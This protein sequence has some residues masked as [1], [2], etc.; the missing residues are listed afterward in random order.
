MVSPISIDNIFPFEGKNLLEFYTREGFSVNIE[1]DIWVLPVTNRAS[2]INFSNIQNLNLKGLIKDFI[3]DQ[4]SRVS[5]TSALN[6]F[7]EISR[8]I[9]SRERDFKLFNDISSKEFEERLISLI[10]DV[11]NAVRRK[12][13]LH[14]FYR[15]REWYVW[16]SEVYPEV[17]FSELYANQLD[18]M[19]IPGNP[20]GE[21]VRMQDPESGPLDR[22]LE[23]PLLINAL[24]EDKSNLYIHLQQ[25][26]VIALSLAFGRNPSNLTYLLESDLEDKTLGIGGEP[27]Y[28]LKMPRIKKGLLNPRDDFIEEYLNSTFAAHVKALINAPKPIQIKYG[29]EEDSKVT[30]NPLF[31]NLS[32]NSYAIASGRIDCKYNMLSTGIGKLIKDFIKRH[33]LVSPLTQ[34]LLHITPRR[35]RY[36]FATGLVLEG[37]SSR[38]LARA[39][40]HTDTQNTTVYFELGEKIVAPLDR[41]IEKGFSKNLNYFKGKIVESEDEAINGKR[42]DKSVFFFDERNIENQEMIGICGEKQLCRLDPPYSCYLCPKFQP[43]RQADHEHVLNC[44]IAGRE[45]K[46]KKYENARLGI[47]LDEVIAAVS[48]VARECERLGKND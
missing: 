43:Y 47:Q 48:Q 12:H 29:D 32:G 42:N 1:S 30:I 11:I 40:D 18:A 16:C 8:F 7:F 13:K 39:L 44:L 41:A 10:E 24:K 4:A 22:V 20:K 21:A 3:V 17:G 26:A 46:L 45:E 36:T 33:N 23:L 27:C 31:I 19:T 6:Y 25:K 37:I 35:L 15:I 14:D 28:C 2:R 5:S 34:K 9:I 38:E